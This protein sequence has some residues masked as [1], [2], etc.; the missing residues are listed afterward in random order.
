MAGGVK[1]KSGDAEGVGG[2]WRGGGA[3]SVESEVDLHPPCWLSRE[4]L[5]YYTFATLNLAD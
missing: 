2:G 4:G 5:R 3:A 1:Q